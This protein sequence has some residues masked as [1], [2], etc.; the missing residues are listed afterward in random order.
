ME[1]PDIVKPD[2]YKKFL[3]QANIDVKTLSQLKPVDPKELELQKNNEKLASFLQGY[4]STDDEITFIGTETGSDT[5]YDYE[6]DDDEPDEFQET[7]DKEKT[8]NTT[9]STDKSV[10]QTTPV[11]QSNESVGSF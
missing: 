9:G 2:L 4:D 7:E 10:N 1:K 8:F 5:A 11:L 3:E 6:I